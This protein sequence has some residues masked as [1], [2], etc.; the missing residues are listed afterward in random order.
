V[1]AAMTF[2]SIA[3]AGVATL[4]NTGSYLLAQTHQMLPLSK[5]SGNT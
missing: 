3:G 4:A 1:I 5:P 2:I